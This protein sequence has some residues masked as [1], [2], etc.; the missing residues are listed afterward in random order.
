MRERW[1]NALGVVSML[2]RSPSTHFSCSSAIILQ[3]QYAQFLSCLHGVPNEGSGQLD[4]LKGNAMCSREE[5]SS[6]PLLRTNLSKFSEAIV[7]APPGVT[8]AQLFLSHIGVYLRSA[9]GDTNVRT[10]GLGAH[11]SQY[12]WA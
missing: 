7:I 6:S 2:A 12:W 4:K 10:T 9:L 8:K 11:R 5:V 1:G 3:H